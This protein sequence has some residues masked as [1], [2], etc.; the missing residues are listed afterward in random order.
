M[1]AFGAVRQSYCFFPGWDAP[2]SINFFSLRTGLA[3]LDVP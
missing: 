1:S 2:G 3:Q